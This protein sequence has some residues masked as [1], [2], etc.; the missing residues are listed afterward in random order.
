MTLTELRYIVAVADH[1]HFGNAADACF[2]TQASLSIGIKKLEDSL[3]VVIF[4]RG[5]V[6][7]LTDAGLPI[8]NKARQ[9]LIAAQELKAMAKIAP[10]SGLRLVA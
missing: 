9:I 6:I 1:L 8:V 4:R 10:Q 3:G 5:R 7:A 2:V